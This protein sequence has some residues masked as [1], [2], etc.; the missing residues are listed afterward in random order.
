MRTYYVYIMA[1]RSRAL[2]AGVTRD[3]TAP[4]RAQAKAFSGL[5]RKVQH[6]QAG[7]LRRP[8]QHSCSDRARKR[9]Q[10]VATCEED[11][12][13]RVEKPSMAGLERWVVRKSR[14]LATL[15]MTEGETGARDDRV[16]GVLA[17]AG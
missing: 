11:C 3:L 7:V 9:D 15:G 2:Y 16:G 8:P 12:F 4:F 10:G 13:D 6:G 5:Y 17:M 14:S 1:S